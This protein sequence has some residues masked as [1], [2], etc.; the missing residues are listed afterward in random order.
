MP[1]T[2]RAFRRRQQRALVRQ[3]LKRLQQLQQD[4]PEPWTIGRILQSDTRRAFRVRFIE[5]GLVTSACIAVSAVT[6]LLTRPRERKAWNEPLSHWTAALSSETVDARDSALGAIEYLQPR[7]R[8]IV[9]SVAPLL[10]DVSMDVREQAVG[11]LVSLAQ[12]SPENASAVRTAASNVLDKSKSRDSQIGAALV[13]RSLGHDVAAASLLKQ[14]INDS[15]DRVREAAVDAL[16]QVAIPGD[17][18]AATRLLTRAHDPSAR[19]RTAA[20][21]AL[22]ALRP[23]DQH[24][25]EVA[26]FAL[27]DSAS[28][29]RE[30]A[31]YALADFGA[32][33]QRYRELLIDA[34]HGPDRGVRAAALHALSRIDAARAPQ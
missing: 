8:T 1:R 4:E 21:A 5:V 6:L 32:G 26:G 7:S 17:D 25:L 28:S 30:E 27:T 19:V 18:D 12:A 16:G 29:V 10:D 13:L 11:T 24:L 3:Q 34:A 23:A 20:L 15:D 33:A 2:L 9:A 14:A 31:A 22:R